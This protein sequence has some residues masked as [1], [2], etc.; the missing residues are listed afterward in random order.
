MSA[1]LNNS[2]VVYIE[3]VS[4]ED[5]ASKLDQ[6]YQDNNAHTMYTST[7]AISRSETADEM[8][9]IE[10]QYNALETLMGKLIDGSRRF[11]R[12]A[13]SNYADADNAASKLFSKDPAANGGAPK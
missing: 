8:A 9:A 3:P 10:D 2:S 7:F 11:L 13:N 12:N 5:A 1:T 4:L 6:L